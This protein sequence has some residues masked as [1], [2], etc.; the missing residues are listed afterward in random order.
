[1]PR[2][3][4]GKKESMMIPRKESLVVLIFFPHHLMQNYC[5]AKKMYLAVNLI[6]PYA[7]FKF[8]M[9]PTRIHLGQINCVCL[10][11]KDLKIYK[12]E[13]WHL[14]LNQVHYVLLLGLS[15]QLF[16]SWLTEAPKEEMEM[17]GRCIPNSAVITSLPK[18]FQSLEEKHFNTWYDSKTFY[19]SVPCTY[20]STV[21]R[22]HWSGKKT[23]WIET[24]KGKYKFVVT[25]SY[26][27]WKLK[28]SV[29]IC[30]NS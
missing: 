29:Y 15:V 25:L 3:P 17:S 5:W 18:R 13:R 26:W 16:Q 8:D 30:E 10:W 12:S 28:L 7:D 21:H 22:H 1:M 27:Y 9:Q 2:S 20:K 11:W 4:L 14:R 23:Y 19:I 6:A 24:I